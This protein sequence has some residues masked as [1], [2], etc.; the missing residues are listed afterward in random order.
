MTPLHW[1]AWE[2]HTGTV[3]VLLQHGAGLFERNG[4]GVLRLA[5]LY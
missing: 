2:G 1:A 5:V 3:Q 4:V